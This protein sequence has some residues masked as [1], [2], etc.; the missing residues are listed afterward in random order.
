MIARTQTHDWRDTAHPGNV[1]HA[2][3]AK[4]ENPKP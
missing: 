3:V 1:P 2:A 4:K